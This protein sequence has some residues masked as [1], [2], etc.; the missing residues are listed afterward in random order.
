MAIRSSSSIN[1]ETWFSYPGRQTIS[2]ITLRLYGIAV[3]NIILATQSLSTQVHRSDLMSFDHDTKHKGSLWPAK[4]D[5]MMSYWEQRLHKALDTYRGTPTKWQGHSTTSPHVEASADD[6]Q[7][8]AGLLVQQPLQEFGNGRTDE[9]VGRIK[10]TELHLCGSGGI[11]FN[12][13]RTSPHLRL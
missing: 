7:E 12:R 2:A 4:C 3:G 11:L 5:E 9:V 8:I 6:I 13:S 1:A 10:V